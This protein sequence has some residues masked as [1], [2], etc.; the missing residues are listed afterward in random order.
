MPKGHSIAEPSTRNMVYKLASP[1]IYR[2]NEPN[3]SRFE[4]PKA[5]KEWKEEFEMNVIQKIEK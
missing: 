5:A 1:A 2:H 4:H 3:L